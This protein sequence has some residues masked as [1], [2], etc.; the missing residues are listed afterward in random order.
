MRHRKQRLQE[1]LDQSFARFRKLPSGQV[2]SACERVLDHLREE[3]RRA[4]DAAGSRL[5]S[6]RPGRSL[7]RVA[8]VIA[9]AAVL[10]AVFLSGLTVRRFIAQ[11]EMYAVVE[12]V[13]GSLYRVSEPSA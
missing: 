11:S 2:D 10:V 5:R 3:T 9:T 6:I 4:P 1:F 8:V 12:T 13:G 7:S